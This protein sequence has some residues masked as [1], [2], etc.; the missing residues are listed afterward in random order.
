R[1]CV[2][3]GERL[4]GVVARQ[5][6]LQPFLRGDPDIERDVTVGV[7]ADAL[8][9]DPASA[10]ASVDGGVVLLTGRL[11]YEDDVAR[12]GLLAGEVPGVVAVHNRPGW[13]WKG[14]APAWAD[15]GPPTGAKDVSRS[16]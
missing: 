8:H 13:F 6:L 14:R 12:A 7:L 2:V 11:E 15:P 16:D 4:I 9:T 1:L 5:D 10:R 3:D